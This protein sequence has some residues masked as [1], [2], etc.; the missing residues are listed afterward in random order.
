LQSQ[1][2]TSI[3]IQTTEILARDVAIA[4]LN[5]LKLPE[6]AGNTYELGGPFVYTL[7]DIY[8]IIH[9]YLERPPKLVYFPR[10]VALKIGIG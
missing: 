7:Q 3:N 9:N 5:A 4:V 1:T 6:T 2:T 10:N 8:E